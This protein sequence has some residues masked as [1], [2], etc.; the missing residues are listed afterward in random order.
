MKSP[1]VRLPQ[2]GN[3]ITKV[4]RAVWL[5][6]IITIATETAIQIVW[7]SAVLCVPQSAGFLE[8][9]RT[10]VCRPMFYLLL[11]LFVVQFIYWILLLAKADLSYVQPITALSLITVAACSVVFFGENVNLIRIAGI[12]MILIGVWLISKTDHNTMVPD[13]LPCA[14]SGKPSETTL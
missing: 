10:I 9:V 7:K 2:V 5:S 3:I 11:S 1:M 14:A 13:V 4:P 6:L 8:T 12:V